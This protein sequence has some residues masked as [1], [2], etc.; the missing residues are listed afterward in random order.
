MERIKSHGNNY[1]IYQRLLDILFPRH[2]AVCDEIVSEAETGICTDCSHKILYIQDP[3]CMKCGRQLK[4]QEKEYCTECDRRTHYFI[5]GTALFDYGSMA[6]SIFRFKYAGRA[7][8]ADFYGKKLYEKKGPWLSMLAADALI[9]VPAHS[10][11]KRERGYNQAELIANVLSEYTG[12]AVNTSL[13][14]RCEK[15]IPMKNLSS[16]ERQNNLK[17]AFKI[18]QNDV[19]LNTIVIIDDIYTTGSTI[20]TLARLMQSEGIQNIYFMTLTIGRG[21]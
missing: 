4:T 6:D 2:C 12:I 19:K 14:K 1:R 15:T 11:R 21:I 13:I 5:Q 7:E 9:P 10:S 20:D 8:Y 16:A 18:C 3:C 17:K